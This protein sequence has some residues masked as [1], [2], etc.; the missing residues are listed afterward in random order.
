[1]FTRADQLLATTLRDRFRYHVI[2]FFWKDFQPLLTVFDLKNGLL[3]TM[4][5]DEISLLFSESKR[6]VGYH[7]QE[8]YH[9][10]PHQASV[11]SF[12]QCRDC[13]ST[14]IP[15]QECIYEPRCRGEICDCRLC[16][17]EHVVYIAF[18]GRLA[19]IGMT[20]LHRLKERGIEQGADAIAPLAICG[21]RKDA[22]ETENLLSKKLKIAQKVPLVS[23]VGELSQTQPEEI[24]RGRL[25][26]ARGIAAELIDPPDEDFIMLDGYPFSPVE[27]DLKP[28]PSPGL[29]RG[30]V[31]GVKG[32][33]LIYQDLFPKAINLSD[34]VARFA[35]PW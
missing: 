6:C 30:Q 5:I 16:A 23:A 4:E 29:H 11:S 10:C 17:A 33:F 32:K 13:A 15:I 22:R 20:Q 19:K 27:G 18:L 7:D 1:M 35:S 24:L 34:T 26:E 28:T 21:S 25:E 3:K 8:G 14:W 12:P 31:I 9:R 2:S